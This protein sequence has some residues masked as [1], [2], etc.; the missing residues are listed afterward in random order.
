MLFISLEI[1]AL[2]CAL[3]L[4]Y[5]I[6]KDPKEPTAAA[7]KDQNSLPYAS[8]QNES[9]SG[10][11]PMSNKDKK[12]LHDLEKLIKEACSEAEALE[13]P[14]LTYALHTALQEIKAIQDRIQINTPQ[15]QTDSRSGNN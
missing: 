15:A 1:A 3:L 5:L 4:V 9:H 14:I 12:R 6:L 11:D 2:L 10:N 7:V 13:E 8:L